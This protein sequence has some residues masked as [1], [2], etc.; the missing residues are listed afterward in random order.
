MKRAARASTA[1]TTKQTTKGA[2]LAQT[3]LSLLPLAAHVPTGFVRL[4]FCARVV[5]EG[6]LSP[7]A[8]Y[9]DL[10][11]FQMSRSCSTFS[12]LS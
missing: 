8:I 4:P 5:S 9:P 11:P 3:T 7:I 2:S 1:R 10:P 6:S 12:A